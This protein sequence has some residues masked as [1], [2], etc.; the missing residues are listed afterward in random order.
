MQSPYYPAEQDLRNRV[1]L[2]PFGL[3]D[4]AWEM[5]DADAY[6]FIGLENEKV[7][8]CVLLWPSDKE[9]HRIQ[10]MQMAVDSSLQQK[11][12]GQQ[13]MHK[14][15]PFCQAQGFKEIYCHARDYAVPFYLKQHFKIYGEAFE[16]VGIQHRYMHYRL[17]E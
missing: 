8:A 2:R 17:A 3:P 14:I 10:L 6:H 11:G 7:L 9:P 4:H 16:E 13:L 15:V 12:I 1:L 5:K